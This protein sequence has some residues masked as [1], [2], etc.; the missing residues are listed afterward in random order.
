MLMNIGVRIGLGR[1]PPEY[2]I[3]VLTCCSA[4]GLLPDLLPL[5]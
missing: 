2:S 3:V 5:T 4:A 1:V